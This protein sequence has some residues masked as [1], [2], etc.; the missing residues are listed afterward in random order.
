MRITW[1]AMVRY[2]ERY[3]GRNFLEL[4]IRSSGND[5]SVMKYLEKVERLDLGRL[6]DEMVPNALWGILFQEDYA[7]GKYFDGDHGVVMKYGMVVTVMKELPEPPP[8]KLQRKAKKKKR[9]AIP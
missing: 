5:Y 3:K 8:Q 6:A 1:H 9:W 2:L 4:K 7:D